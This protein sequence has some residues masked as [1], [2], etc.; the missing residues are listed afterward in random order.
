MPASICTSPLLHFCLGAILCCTLIQ[1]KHVLFLHGLNSKVTL[2]RVFKVEEIMVLQF[3]G[4]E[5]R[6]EVR[7]Q[8]IAR[9]HLGPP[10]TMLQAQQV[11][12]FQ[13]PTPNPKPQTLNLNLRNSGMLPPPPPPPTTPRPTSQHL[14]H[15]Y[16]GLGFRVQGSE[17]RA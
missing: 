10:R 1:G 2:G 16:L 15:G 6:G 11:P 7:I 4:I 5:S 14:T 13:L 12:N 17:F 3:L 8:H 9:Q